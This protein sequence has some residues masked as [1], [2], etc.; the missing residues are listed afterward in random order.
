MKKQF[1]RMRQNFKYFL[2]ASVYKNAIEE[3]R[4]GPFLCNSMR[5][6]SSYD[7]SK[8]SANLENFIILG[9]GLSI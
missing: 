1:T 8:K 5:L 4:Q 9:N 7:Q 3:I 6:L 2:N